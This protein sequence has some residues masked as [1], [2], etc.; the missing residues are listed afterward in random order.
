MWTL[1]AVMLASFMLGAV[2]DPIDDSHGFECYDGCPRLPDLVDWHY[3]DADC[4]DYVREAA[5]AAFAKWD[6]VDFRYQGAHRQHE[7]DRRPTIYCSDQAT[8][9]LRQLPPGINYQ[10][11]PLQLGTGNAIGGR[12]HLYWLHSRILD[13]DIEVFTSVVTSANIDAVMVHEVGHGVGLAHSLNPDAL[14]APVLQRGDLHIDDLAGVNV[15]YEVCEDVVDAEMNLFLHKLEG[16]RGIVPAGGI[17][18]DHARDV[19]I[20]EC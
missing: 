18:P 9:S 7:Y 6:V 12:T 14:M 19:A 8:E 3:D 1:I 17:W 13:F 5:V 10:V 2:L 15:L 16:F 4:P 20:S 11:L